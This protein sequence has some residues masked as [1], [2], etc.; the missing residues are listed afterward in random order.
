ML[1]VFRFF[2]EKM[3]GQN[4]GSFGYPKLK[5]VLINLDCVV[6]GLDSFEDGIVTQRKCP[7]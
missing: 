4:G 2:W 1:P 3:G 7:L 6:L 5:N